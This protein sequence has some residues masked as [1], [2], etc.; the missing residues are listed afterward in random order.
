MVAGKIT[1]F[2]LEC[3]LNPF[4]KRE[5]ERKTLRCQESSNALEPTA[6]SKGGV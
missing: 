4:G 1:E 6:G 3:L 5:S 2:S